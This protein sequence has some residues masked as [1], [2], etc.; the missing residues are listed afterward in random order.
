MFKVGDWVIEKSTNELKQ[1][2]IGKSENEESKLALYERLCI[3][4]QPQ[5]GEWCWFKKEFVKVNRIEESGYIY[6]DTTFG[7]TK[8]CEESDLSFLCEP[9]IGEL[10]SFIKE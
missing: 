8:W 9:F 7:D 4:W 1:V 3:L 2:K 5:V 6:F 10:P